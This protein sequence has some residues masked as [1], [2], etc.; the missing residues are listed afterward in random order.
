VPSEGGAGPAAGT[1]RPAD[2]LV[3]Q[4]TAHQS[5][6]AVIGGDVH[7][8]V[9]FGGELRSPADSVLDFQ[10]LIDSAARDFI[11]RREVFTALQAFQTGQ[12]CGYFEIV[13]D[14]GLG[15]TALAAEIVR[16]YK[17]IPFF[18]SASRG[19]TFA[20]QFLTHLSA[21]LITHYRL[22]YDH[23]PARGGDDSTFFASVLEQATG[24]TQDQ[25]WIV[26][27]ALDEAEP[28]PRGANPLLLPAHLP[29]RAYV[30]VTHRPGGRLWTQPDTPRVSYELQA[31]ARE[32][33]ADVEEFVR[34]RAT[35]DDTIKTAL[36]SVSPAVLPEQFV[37]RL[38]KASRGNF[39]Y[40]SYVLGDI[41]TRNAEGT[42][43]DLERL[44][45]GLQGYY[46]RFWSDMQEAKAE[47]WA[48][49]K[50]LYR[51]IIERLAVAAEAVTA[52]WLGAEVGRDADE[53]RERALERWTRLLSHETVDGREVWRVV[54]QSFADFLEQKVDV[55]MAH[56]AIAARYATN[57]WNR[58][59]EFDD[60]GLR[61]TPMHLAA[62]AGAEHD[63]AK[64]H[65]LTKTLAS[66]VLSPGF[67]QTHLARFGDP[68]AFEHAVDLAVRHMALDDL[69]TAGELAEVALRLV[70]FRKEQRRPE[71]IFELAREGN[72]EAAERRLDLFTLEVD[73]T[74]YQ[75]LLLTIAW[76]GA[77][78]NPGLARALRNRVRTSVA[79]AP[80][81]PTLDLLLARVN[82]KLDSTPLPPLSL[83]PPPPRQIAQAIILRLGA[84][85]VDRSLMSG[86]DMELMNRPEPT[87][88]KGYL[89]EE[90]GR[91]LVAVVHADESFGEPLLKQ[92]V[93]MHAAYGYREYRQGSLWALL[94]AV[95]QHPSQEWT[96]AWVG[97]LGAAVLAPNRGDFREGLG[98]AALALQGAAGSPGAAERLEGRR[99]DALRASE[100]AE[101]LPPTNLVVDPPPRGQGDTWGTNRRR[102]AALAE[103][104]SRVPGHEADIHTLLERALKLEWGFAGFN[105]PARL[106]LAEA[107][108][109]SSHDLAWIADALGGARTSAHN[110]QDAVF[111]ARTTARVQ[112]LAE[113]W[114]GSPPVG[115]FNVEDAAGRLARDASGPEFAALHVIG[116]QYNDRDP[117]A[118]IPL[119][120]ELLTA[121]TPKQ[122]AAVY[123]R[124][125]EEFYRLN[126]DRP[127]R[128]DDRLPPGTQVNVPDPGFAP[129]LAARFAARALADPLLSS[130]RQQR[131]IRALVPIAAADATALDLVLARLLLA[132]HSEDL[133]MLDNLVALAALSETIAPPD[134]ALGAQLTRFVP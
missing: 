126:S 128:R 118:T 98:L 63:P 89:A 87:G 30:V 127:L 129:L 15:K 96:L 105:A 66:L 120:S 56:R 43:L 11:G 64:R 7:G 86:A 21:A 13:A 28:P 42:L 31:D 110:I 26:V 49:W 79:A 1:S 115:A 51:P 69:A 74:W 39:M 61:H 94:A 47:G 52:Q 37:S 45:D 77:S 23:V 25:I 46:E 22:P 34:R 108:E 80:A 41:T 124:P 95:L 2:P 133:V 3:A 18:A 35:D 81:S 123:E 91:D 48:D 59:G 24:T 8:N 103:A 60:Y 100:T 12:A 72:I 121:A 38:V 62:A 90:D 57:L 134:A 84:S 106:A 122:L 125:L 113:R 70:A 67:Q 33:E 85:T 68:N 119:P 97:A 102:L 65:T 16:R 54:H 99:T 27:D 20:R 5:N 117:G 111:C 88:P 130:D 6:V 82:A 75:A 19:L 78:R 93:A 36:A 92:Y 114:W 107:I 10:Q 116:Q 4:L 76:L 29:T 44:P 58:W 17:A 83:P 109:V 53:V 104:L 40:V 112:A 9:I 32:Q 71:P 101:P 131:V 50:G 14:A 55:A 73:A 132:S